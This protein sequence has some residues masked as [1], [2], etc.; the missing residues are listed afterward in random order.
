MQNTKRFIDVLTRHQIYVEGVKL[1]QAILFNYTLIEFKQELEKLFRDLKYK[2]LNDMNKGVLIALIKQLREMQSIVY[3][4]YTTQL[5]K[6]L[7]E[8]MQADLEL[9]KIIFVTVAEDFGHVA[10]SN[11]SDLVLEKR[12]YEKEDKGALFPLAYITGKGDRLF[13]AIQN[14]PIPAN[15][16]LLFDFINGFVDSA[17]NSIENIVRQ[18][19]A[20]ADATTTM[21]DVYDSIIGTEELNFR[22]GQLNRIYNQNAAVTATSMQHVTSVV[23]A[24]IA[25]LLFGA[26][27]W[28]SV[29]DNRTTEI[30]RKRNGNVYLYGQG[31]LP[32]AHINCRS[33]VVPAI[34][35]EANNAPESFY[36]WANEQPEEV[37]RDIMQGEKLNKN[38]AFESKTPLTIQ[39]F[40]NKLPLILKR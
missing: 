30:C 11:Y 29:L 25:S 17:S 7:F 8:F 6:D 22:D 40:K 33:K 35:G 19:Y 15:G 18:G 36:M 13:T 4:K 28:L 31:P 27:R 9:S 23:Q 39:E 37:K 14:A 16:I 38:S 26:Y 3:D 20:N 24:G 2:K 5:L 1:N 32:P 12:Y 21:R 10:N 34:L